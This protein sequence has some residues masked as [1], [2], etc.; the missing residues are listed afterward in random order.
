MRQ[1]VEGG[2]APRVAASVVRNWTRVYG[3]GGG[4]EGGSELRLCLHGGLG[5]R[6]SSHL[7]F[8]ELQKAFDS[9]P[10]KQASTNLLACR[11]GPMQARKHPDETREC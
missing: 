5:D 11:D 4:G 8:A 1:A 2:A 6:S 3:G 10:P 7:G 9:R